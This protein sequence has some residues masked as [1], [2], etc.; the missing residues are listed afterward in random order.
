MNLLVLKPIITEKSSAQVVANKFTFLVDQDANKI[1]IKKYFKQI[2]DVNVADVNIVNL[3][4]KKRIRGRIVG[5]TKPKKKAILTI[6][7]GENLEKIKA[8][9]G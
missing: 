2:Y 3:K 9:F 5:Y 8:I 4:P 1:E 6:K 7:D